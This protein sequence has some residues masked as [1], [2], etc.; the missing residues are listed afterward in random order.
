[1]IVGRLETDGERLARVAQYDFPAELQSSIPREPLITSTATNDARGEAYG[2]DM[3]T[4]WE[5][6]ASS[7]LSGWASYTLGRARRDAY[8]R[9]YAFEYDRPHAANLAAA[10]RLRPSLTF[11][12]TLRLASGFPRTPPLGLRVDAIP[13]RW[14]ADGDGNSGE[15]VPRRDADG[16]L[17]YTVDLGGV[18]NLN[19]GRLPAYVRLDVRLTYA[20]VRRRWQLYADVINVLNR[21]NAGRLDPQLAYNPNSNR[22]RI[23]EEREMSLPLLP[24]AGFRF[25]F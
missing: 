9:S 5:P 13:D 11:A 3:F 17:V 7:P 10:Y 15:L 8:G 18:S 20:P 22:P 25:R 12:S 6:G 14:D 16:R 24:S 4:F 19:T 21:R 23:V 2:I 1:L